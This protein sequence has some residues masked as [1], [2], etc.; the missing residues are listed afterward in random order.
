MSKRHVR[1]AVRSLLLFAVGLVMAGAGVALGQGAQSNADFPFASSAE[2]DT[3]SARAAVSTNS[4]TRLLPDGTYQ[5]FVA[6]RKQQGLA[7]IHTH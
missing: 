1:V 3:A 2:I 5:Y 6:T 7:E 4:V